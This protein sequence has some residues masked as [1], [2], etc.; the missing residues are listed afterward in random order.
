MTDIRPR[1]ILDELFRTSLTAFIERAF[2]TL[3]PEQEYLCGFHIDAIA[4]HLECV[5]RGEINR[6]TIALP[7]RHLKSHC[8]SVAFPAWVLGR[9]PSKRIVAASYAA[10]LAEGFSMQTRKIM[11]QPWYRRVFPETIFD[12]KRNTLEEIRTTRHGCRIATSVGGALTGMGGNIVIVDDPLKAGE[13]LSEAARTSARNWFTTTLMTRLNNPKTDAIV[14]VS[15]RLHVDD[16]IGLTKEQGGWVH[17]DLPATAIEY[18]KIPLAKS[19]VW[20]R[21][22]G[23]ILQPE[24]VGKAELK[25]FRRDL[26]GPNYEAQ[27]QQQPVPLEGNL[28]KMA[29]FKRYDEPPPHEQFEIMVQ[30]WDTAM[31]P[32]EGNDYSVCT[33]WGILGRRFYLLHLFREQLNYPDLR[34]TVIKLKQKFQVPM[35]IVESAGSGIQLYQDIDSLAGER[36]IYNLKPDGDKVSRLAHQSAKIEEGLVYL[37]ENA[38]WLPAFVSELSAFPNSKHDDQVD[39]LTQFLRTLDYAPYPLRSLSYYTGR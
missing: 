28:V 2:Y 12:P 26:G 22:P 14:L 4:H 15:Q 27:F 10:G 39:S 30:S 38:P 5:E 17:L 7:P 9:D 3:E 20:R 33:T 19:G 1:V 32:G 29:W 6:L 18:Q 13:S 31:V 23:N 16:L 35:V 36:W 8:A 21:Q 11:S 24:R 25:Q 37:P 34:R